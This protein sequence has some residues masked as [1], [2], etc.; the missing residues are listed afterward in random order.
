MCNK[1]TLPGG[2]V[3]LRFGVTCTDSASSDRLKEHLAVAWPS[4]VLSGLN[5][6]FSSLSHELFNLI[7]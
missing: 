4:P 5:C 6:S 7:T 1:K 3:K 2:V